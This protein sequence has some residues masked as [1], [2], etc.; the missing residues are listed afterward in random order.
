MNAK[1]Q[2]IGLTLEADLE[3]GDDEPITINLRSNHAHMA[4]GVTCGKVFVVFPR[5][6]EALHQLVA[7]LYEFC[8]LD[9]EMFP[10]LPF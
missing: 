4:G 5:D 3:N 10:Q 2:G 9:R 8:K 1:E 6:R 7:K